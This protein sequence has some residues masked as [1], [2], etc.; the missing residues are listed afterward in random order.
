MLWEKLS[1]IKTFTCSSGKWLGEGEVR[2]ESIG[3]EALIFHEKGKWKHGPTF[4]NSLRWILV[5]SKIRLEHLRLGE[6]QPTFLVEFDASGESVTPHLCGQDCYTAKIYFDQEG[7]HLVWTV[8]GPMKN[9]Q[10]HYCYK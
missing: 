10:Y 9:E 1:K 7:F 3:K 5:G 6:D 2:V 4:T 8:L